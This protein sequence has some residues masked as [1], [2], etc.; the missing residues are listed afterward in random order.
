MT[1]A[2]HIV[3][4]IVRA[5]INA[6]AAA[7]GIWLLV[8]FEYISSFGELDN[9][10]GALPAILILLSIA[11]LSV[12][13]WMKHTK[14]FLPACIALAV[15]AV[16]SASLVPAALVG[17]WWI[18]QPLAA[19]TEETDIS[20]YE[21]FTEG[22]LTAKLDEESTL[23]LDD[24][25]L[26][27]GATALYPVY[28]AFVEAV[29]AED[30]Y[31][32]DKVLCTKTNKAYA[33]LIAG[34]RDVIFVLDAAQSQLDAAEA[35]GAELEFTPIGKE[36]FVFL[37]A[38]SN[39]VNGLTYK[40]I[41]D[42]YSGKTAMWSTLGWK[43]GG[44]IVSFRRPEGSGSQTGLQKVMRDMPIQSRTL[45]DES[46]A[47]TNSLMKQMSVEWNGVQPALGYSY[48]FFAKTMYSNPDVK[49]LEVDG[50]YPSDE[51]IAS[52]KYP[53]VFTFYAVTNGEPTGNTK[54]FIDWI[55]SAQGQEL[56]KKTGYTPI[57]E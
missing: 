1:A 38:K 20:V 34:N 46:L 45:P 37:A 17:G 54:T 28:A 29:S 15:A 27:D 47:G 26:M 36:A 22:S 8:K 24:L 9:F 14:K 11:A 7:V 53:F 25:P 23:K 48:K 50:V 55:C 51:N 2:K 31:D 13:L 3:P 19:A 39:P 4:I 6:A 21:P 10:L 33:E 41:K 40:Q 56:V 18:E 42:I 12:L 49:I 44:E 30:A 16:I 35:A 32:P 57:G 52:G 5:A 43:E